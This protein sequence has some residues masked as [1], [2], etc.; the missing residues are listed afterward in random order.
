CSTAVPSRS[1]APKQNGFTRGQP[2]TFR[3]R[4]AYVPAAGSIAYTSASGYVAANSNAVH[5]IFAPTST[6]TRGCTNGSIGYSPAVNTFL[7]T[8]SMNGEYGYVN[9]TSR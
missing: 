9:V 2:A 8:N 4:Y 5:P 7:H 3:A 6:I 1:C